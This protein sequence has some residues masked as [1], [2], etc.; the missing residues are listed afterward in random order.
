MALSE[1]LFSGG[2]SISKNVTVYLSNIKIIIIH[3]CSFSLNN[4]KPKQKI[5]TSKE[6]LL[7]TLDS[8]TL[9]T[10]NFSSL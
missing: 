2:T 9:G 3:M 10:L 7:I 6:K 4:S 1:P 8:L 5:L